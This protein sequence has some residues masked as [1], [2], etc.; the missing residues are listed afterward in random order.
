MEDACGN[1]GLRPVI[2]F[3]MGAAGPEKR[4]VA[5]LNQCKGCGV[6]L[7]KT[8]P[9]SLLAARGAGLSFW[10]FALLHNGRAV[11]A[12]LFHKKLQIVG[13]P[14]QWRNYSI[15]KQI[16]DGW[17]PTADVPPSTDEI[18]KRLREKGAEDVKR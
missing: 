1:C 15:K 17:I 8:E 13:V 18:R 2:P 6:S 11:Q 9:I 14:G 3:N 7:S 4:G 16:W 12:S 10:D 5:Y